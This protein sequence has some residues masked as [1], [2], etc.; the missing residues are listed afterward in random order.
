[1]ILA[2]LIVMAGTLRPLWD[3]DLPIHLATGEW[4][5][6]HRA[7]PRVEPFAWTRAGAPFYTVGW[8]IQLA[9]YATFAHF[10]PVGLRLLNGLF[11]G[12]AGASVLPLG[13]AARWPAPVSLAIAAANVITAALVTSGLR[14]QLLLFTIVPLAWGLAYALASR[15]CLRCYAG[16]FAVSALAV[17]AHLFFPLVLVPVLAL[18]GLGWLPIGRAAA[19][20]TSVAA[21]WLATP[22]VSDWPGVIRFVTAPNPLFRYPAAIAELRPGF[23][24]VAGADWSVGVV[25]LPLLALPWLIDP[26]RLTV[27]ERIVMA[28]FWSAGCAIFGA[29]VRGVA[30]WWLLVLPFTAQALRRTSSSAAPAAPARS[31]V[32]LGVFGLSACALLVQLAFAGRRWQHEGASSQRQ[33]SLD[34]AAGLDPVIAWLSDNTRSGS[35]GRILTTFD[36]GGYLTWRMPGYSSSVD[37]RGSFPDSILEPE[38]LVYAWS[39]RARLG[40]WRSA[41]LAIVPTAWRV[42]GV[43][44]TAAGWHRVVT[45]PPSG[46]LADTVGLWVR[47]AWWRHVGRP[48]PAGRRFPAFPPAPV[49]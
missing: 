40:P 44:D 23:L 36:Y 45:V 10:G 22:Y 26:Q 38:A 2:V 31:G 15:S 49:P 12:A 14:P 8:A 13:R 42:A 28:A 33:L 24:G 32:K 16:L 47:D 48:T 25:V 37:S 9:F 4:I 20:A 29:A 19:A 21:G 46:P 17:N 7:V 43:L 35:G 3:P 5:A 27:R 30:I 1:L 39:A 6:E 18:L 41:D 11:L 34:I